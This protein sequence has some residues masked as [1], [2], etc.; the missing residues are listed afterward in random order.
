M[1]RSERYHI[2]VRIDKQTW[3][4]LNKAAISQGKTKSQVARSMLNKGLKMDGYKNDDDRLYQMILDAVH[5]VLDPQVKR[6][7]AIMAKDTH[8]SATSFFMQVAFA[9]ACFNEDDGDS[10]DEAV[11]TA[12]RL[13]IEY[14]KLKDSDLERFFQTNVS[15]I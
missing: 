1:S 4:Q 12:R 7:A 10:I 9:K 6:F 14:L 8:V 5:E 15:K 13:A 11:H 3:E 2:D